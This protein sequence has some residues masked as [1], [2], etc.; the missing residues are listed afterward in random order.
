MSG[1]KKRKSPAAEAREQAAKTKQAKN[2]R[3]LLDTLLPEVE[4]LSS[5]QK[6]V[7]EAVQRR[8]NVFVTGRAGCGKSNV[9]RCLM[10]C[11]DACG[12]HYA[13]T[14]PTGIAAEQI[15]GVTIHSLT[16]LNEELDI[17]TCITRAKRYKKKDLDELEVLIV[18]EVSM[19]SEQTFNMVLQILGA[20]HPLR[21]PVMVLVGD[22]LQLPPVQ[23][24]ILLGTPTWNLLKMTT[25]LLPECFRQDSAAFLHALDEARKGS[26]SSESVALFRSRVGALIPNDIEPT[27]LMPLRHTVDDINRRRLMQLEGEQQT[28]VG[29]VYIGTRLDTGSWV[30]EE[31]GTPELPLGLDA[32]PAS[33]RGVTVV[34]PCEKDRWMEAASLVSSSMFSAVLNLAVGAQ[35]VFIANISPQIVNGTRGVV[36]AF[37]EDGRPVVRMMNGVEFPVPLWQRAKRVDKAA[38]MPCL[39]FEQLPLQLA[40]ALTIHKSQGMSL[41]LAKLDLGRAVF[42]HGQAYV[43]LSRLRTIEGMVLLDFNPAGVTANPEIV[44]WYREAEEKHAADTLEDTKTAGGAGT[45]AGTPSEF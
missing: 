42:S 14:A 38:D 1:A 31:G 20:F 21:L 40:W 9:I 4:L 23:G 6:K 33:L 24:T 13:V 19:L 30:M 39:V 28:F 15:G 7:I 26:L 12:T 11:M 37:S 3:L 41:D 8:E 45:G 22:F 10:K 25:I 32:V 29:K 36:V 18:D 16:G 43:A 5:T 34:L 17:K 35:V 44:K 27:I 2:T